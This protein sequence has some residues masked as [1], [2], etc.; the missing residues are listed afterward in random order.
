M[1]LTTNIKTFLHILRQ[2]DFGP[3]QQLLSVAK[4]AISISKGQSSVSAFDETQLGIRTFLLSYWQLIQPQRFMVICHLTNSSLSRTP[5][6]ILTA[7]KVIYP[8]MIYIRPAA[9][10]LLPLSYC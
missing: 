4:T 3:A 7:A 5:A 9:I 10:I 6:V 2:L 8:L 1:W